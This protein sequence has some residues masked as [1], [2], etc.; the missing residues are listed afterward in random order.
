MSD[1][2]PMEEVSPGVFVA[3]DP[4]TLE[5]AKAKLAKMGA[6]DGLVERATAALEGVT[7]GP[8]DFFEGANS[9]VFDTRITAADDNCVAFSDGP[10]ARFIAFTRQW[11]PEAAAHIAALTAKVA[12]LRAV[13]REDAMELLAAHGQAQGAYAAQLAAEAEAATMR[14]KLQAMHRRAQKAEGL[15]HRSANQLETIMLSVRG[16]MKPGAKLPLH[17]L[18]HRICAA[19][20]HARAS[21]GRAWIE[22]WHYLWPQ[23]KD[24]EAERDALRA[25]VACA[26][27][28]ALKKAAAL[29]DSWWICAPDGSDMTQDV[30]DAILALTDGGNDE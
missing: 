21:S 10:D 27:A 11:V 1:T 15:S 5:A 12:E 7:D 13:R 19:R 29:F 24:A 8:W 9:H 25:K 4:E 2:W 14:L 26:R 23:L 16:G 20:D 30:Q 28:E 18:F 17:S 3:V 22:G 6:G